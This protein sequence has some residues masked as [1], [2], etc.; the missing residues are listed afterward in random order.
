[1]K[2]KSSKLHAIVPLLI[3]CSVVTV[4]ACTRGPK[5]GARCGSNSGP[6]PGNNCVMTSCGSFSETCAGAGGYYSCIPIPYTATCTT[7][8][9]TLYIDS[10]GTFCGDPST[11]GAPFGTPC[12]TTQSLGPGCI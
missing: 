3:G 9:Y 12:T 5:T 2:P 7:T 6:T 8:Y 11:V 10:E 4:L 1:M